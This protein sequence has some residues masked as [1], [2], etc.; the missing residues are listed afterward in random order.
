MQG[1]TFLLGLAVGGLCAAI[2]AWLL[3]GSP[4]QPGGPGGTGNA[5]VLDARGEPVGDDVIALREEIRRL[6]QELELARNGDGRTP[7][8]GGTGEPQ[9]ASST[10]DG[11]PAAAVAVVPPDRRTELMLAELDELLRS[12]FLEERFRQQPT[13]LAWFLLQSWC[14]VGHPERALLLLKR[15]DL[16]EEGAGYASWIGDLLEQKGDPALAAE[17]YLMALAAEPGDWS[18]IMSLTRLDPEAALRHRAEHPPVQ[19]PDADYRSQTALLML[20]AGRSEE[21]LREIDALLAEGTL[22]EPLWNELVQRDPTAAEQRLRRLLEQG[23]TE[24][25][26][27]LRLHVVRAL[28]NQGKAEQARS[29]ID[30]MLSEWPDHGPAVQALAD[31][32]R[33]AALDYLQ[34]RVTEQPNPT[35][36][37][38]YGEQLLQS[39]RRED[40]VAAFYEAWTMAPDAGYQYRL[41]ELAPERF[42]TRMAEQA[43]AQNDDELFGDIA[44]ALWQSGRH[45]EAINYWRRALEIDSTDSEWIEKL[46]AV[47]SGRD[48]MR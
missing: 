40:A 9:E 21:A 39:E 38:L 24:D 28:C 1:R 47:D 23:A 11:G 32:D 31:M 48:P 19:A 30:A 6:R 16:A 8:D 44:D 5:P 17:A 20:G 7:V 42:A 25:D 13:E 35:A 12:G 4:T 27:T 3:R 15:F 46:R 29:E 43:D 2:P 34:R 33:R 36:W 14:E 26:G 37:G 18:A 41:L 45:Q 10:T 22:S